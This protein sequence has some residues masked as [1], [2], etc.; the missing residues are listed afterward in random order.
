MNY[1]RS[2]S[3]LM[4]KYGARDMYAFKRV[5]K[6]VVCDLTFPS[7]CL[8]KKYGA[9]DF[10]RT[11]NGDYMLRLPIDS[12]SVRT[13]KNLKDHEIIYVNPDKVN[14]APNGVAKAAIHTQG[15][16]SF[17]L[18]NLDVKYLVNACN[19]L[20]RQYE[21][22]KLDATRQGQ[23]ENE[24]LAFEADNTFKSNSMTDADMI[25]KLKTVNSQQSSVSF[26]N[27]NDKCV[28][29]YRVSDDLASKVI[30]ER[31]VRD[32]VVFKSLQ[33]DYN[34]LIEF[35]NNHSIELDDKHLYEHDDSLSIR[36][37]TYKLGHSRNAIYTQLMDYCESNFVADAVPDISA[38]NHMSVYLSDTEAVEPVGNKTEQFNN[39]RG[40]SV[41]DKDGSLKV[42]THDDK[43]FVASYEGYALSE[44]EQKQ[45]ASGEEI[46]LSEVCSDNSKCLYNIRC[47][48][49]KLAD[50]T[51]NDTN[52]GIV[53]SGYETIKSDAFRD[54]HKNEKYR[55]YKSDFDLALA[56]I[57]AKDAFYHTK[58][59][60]DMKRVVDRKSVKSLKKI[61]SAENKSAR[62]NGWQKGS[63][64]GKQ[65]NYF[66]ESYID[67]GSKA[68]SVIMKHRNPMLVNETINRL[69]SQ[70]ASKKG[71][72]LYGFETKYDELYFQSNL[73]SQ[74]ATVNRL[75]ES[76]D[77]VNES[78]RANDRAKYLQNAIDSYEALYNE[79]LMQL[80]YRQQPVEDK[81]LQSK[82]IKNKWEEHVFLMN[83]KLQNE[84][85]T[86][87]TERYT[88]YNERLNVAL[89]LRNNVT[90]ETD[91]TLQ[92]ETP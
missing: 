91:D 71:N 33:S 39:K 53:V 12:K 4:K 73:K 26:T 34:D 17:I 56:H 1:E 25:G 20:N 32:V 80:D 84:P 87:V 86:D 5:G 36:D 14:I 63:I 7:Y 65:H 89:R 28:R 76:L 58:C 45:L 19:R 51:Y 22:S 13:Y 78:S 23:M 3:L 8:C 29:R 57:E 44:Y 9:D 48:L 88:R 72:E 38:N 16:Q 10:T 92:V 27:K 30:D 75:K 83:Q 59:I 54:V 90:F 81:S 70:P 21:A 55:M 35:A 60:D 69:S 61:M 43:T 74:K 47:K 40:L 41:Y 62:L 2:C 77:Y 18:R 50:S 64:S 31:N 46:V 11:K 42:C 15:K 52:Y 85:K 49:D 67:V 79:S 37:K 82:G 66:V 24:R 6:Q 68:D